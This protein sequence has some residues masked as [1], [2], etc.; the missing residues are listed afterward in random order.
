[1][2]ARA[3]LQ[4]ASLFFYQQPGLHWNV[5]DGGMRKRREEDNEIE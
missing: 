3:S 4:S 1:M 5:R 2:L